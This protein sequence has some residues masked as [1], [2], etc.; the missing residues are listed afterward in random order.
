M[1]LAEKLASKPQFV[2]PASVL[3][4]LGLTNGMDVVD[5]ASGAGHWSIAAAKLVA[6]KGKVLAIENDINM[7][8]MI[9]SRAKSENL[10][11]I[12]IETLELEKGTSKE[13]KPSDLVIMSNIM[14][15]IRDKA[16][17][18]AKAAKMVSS[19]GRLLFMDW[20][21]KETLFGP[22]LEL[23]LQQEQVII[24]FEEAGLIFT[25]TVDTGV[26]HFGL[27]FAREG[28]KNEK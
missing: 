4:E 7:L 22:P 12:E 17:F 16:V 24:L 1:D 8:N 6:P 9:N 5:Y 13:A 27:V 28:E 10:N 3:T 19:K 26:D 11:N 15:L 20:A 14:H 18:A 25:K 21:P 2:S 23:R